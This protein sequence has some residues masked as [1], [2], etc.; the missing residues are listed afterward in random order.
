MTYWSDKVRRSCLMDAKA[1]LLVF[2]NAERQILEIAHR[3]A[4]GEKTSDLT[5]IRGTA[6]LT[7]GAPPGWLELEST[8]LDT[9]GALIDHPDPLG[10]SSALLSGAQKINK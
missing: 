8:E 7:R 9:P 10:V 3:L 1:D 5:D 6:Y 4:G 2:G